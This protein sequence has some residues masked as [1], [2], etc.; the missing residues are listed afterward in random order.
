MSAAS[1]R[2]PTRTGG[3][4]SES[5]RKAKRTKEDIMTQIDEAGVHFVRIFFTDVLGRLKGMSITR[6]EIEDVLEQ[7][8]GNVVG[9]HS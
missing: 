6:S 4:I 2:V 8:Q 7:G 3:V 9:C 1:N 5:Q